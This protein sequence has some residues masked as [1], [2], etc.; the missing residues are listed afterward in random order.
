MIW[1]IILAIF[2]Y[3]SYN[4][5]YTQQDES[6]QQ[7][8]TTT[9]ILPTLPPVRIPQT[10]TLTPRDSIAGTVESVNWC[11]EI[12]KICWPH[13]G[14]IVQ[15]QLKPTVEPL[16][17]LYLPKP[18]SKFRFV[19]AD[20]GSDP[21]K[22]ER[23]VVHHRYHDSIALD[24]DVVFI[25]SPNM[26]MKCSPLSATFG[27]KQLI[28]KG[29]LA[30]LLRPLITAL[31]LVGAIQASMITHPEFDMDF[32]GVANLAEIGPIFK[33]VKMVLS[34]VIASMLV[35]PNRFLYKIVES[36][37][38][39]NVYQPP[40]GVL[41]VTID[42][43]R[44][45]TKEKKIGLIKSVPDLYCKA[46]FALEEMKTEVRMNNL[47]P[48][49][50]TTKSF[51]LSD[52][53]QPFELS[54]YDKDTITK[55]DLVGTISLT[56]KE[57]LHH[58]GGWLRFQNII[59]PKIGQD[60]EIFLCAQYYKFQDPSQP[61]HGR[62]VVSVLIDKATGLPK[63]TA[64]AACRV[65]VGNGGTK[66]VVRETPQIISANPPL[67]GIDPENPSWN[68]SFDILVDDCTKAD[69]SIEVIEDKK[70]LGN[71]VIN[72]SVL[73]NSQTNC[74]NE[75]FALGNGAML[76]AKVLLRGLVAHNLE[77]KS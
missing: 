50:A 7:G 19:S 22:I 67:P 10:F 26:T 48:D 30:V 29:R 24:L 33:I 74:S 54:C 43:G 52:L 18:F 63:G 39:F 46:T 40:L 25:G 20:L 41:A 38:Y 28:W 23:V 37:D 11:N 55:D 34:N 42:K 31:P 44:G 36:V 56:A 17:N 77:F 57:F 65:I 59:E 61:I 51:I 16:I 70:V 4:Y 58:G 69:V 5:L 9:P 71:V 13:I 49:W 2:T 68:F 15:S 60:G 45:F 21:L 27:I 66:K 12:T 72:S 14:K 1:L 8:T 76:R 64:S 62:C 73:E 3:F 47:T 35:L 75:Q 53:D 32:T 6:E